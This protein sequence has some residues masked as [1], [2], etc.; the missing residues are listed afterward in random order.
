MGL[1]ISELSLR[2]HNKVFQVKALYQL[3]PGCLSLGFQD[4][5]G[6]GSSGVGLTER[7]CTSKAFAE[8]SL[9][10]RQRTVPSAS[11]KTEGLNLLSTLV[12]GSY[13]A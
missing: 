8:S 1:P 9:T 3:C 6:I 2:S 10:L 11:D 5:L 13:F 12:F 7:D 4:F